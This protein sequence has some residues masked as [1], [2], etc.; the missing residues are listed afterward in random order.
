M[1]NNNDLR[2]KNELETVYIDSSGK[3]HLDYMEALCAETQIQMCRESKLQQ[4]QKIMD[5]IELVMQVLKSENWGV[6]YK[7]QPIQPLETQDGNALYRV[8]QVDECEIETRIEQAL[9]KW[10]SSQNDSN[11][12]K[13][14]TTG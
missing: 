5:I 2:L 13:N 9:T 4:K 11:Q 6:F 8:N 14:S 7:N 10:E 3:K 1:K 12:N